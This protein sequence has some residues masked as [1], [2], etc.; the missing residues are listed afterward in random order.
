MC[1]WGQDFTNKKRGIF[2]EIQRGMTLTTGDDSIFNYLDKTSTG[3]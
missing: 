2:G 1:K 3:N